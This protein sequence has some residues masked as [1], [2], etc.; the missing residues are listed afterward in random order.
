MSSPT[1]LSSKLSGVLSALA[2][3]GLLLSPH[4]ARATLIDV[5]LILKPDKATGAL[6]PDGS[7]VGVWD[8]VDH[9]LSLESFAF[10]KTKTVFDT[11]PDNLDDLIDLALDD[12]V[13]KWA[14]SGVV[15]DIADTKQGVGGS[16]SGNGWSGTWKLAQRVPEPGGVALLGIALFALG[17]AHRIRKTVR[18]RNQPP[19]G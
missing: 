17:L 15:F 18:R 2:L 13:L 4:A 7:G 3:G 12:F 5:D 8:D 10:K 9:T 16:Y 1:S 19:R 11:A 14:T 6:N